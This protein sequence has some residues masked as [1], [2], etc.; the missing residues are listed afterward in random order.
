MR[1]PEIGRIVLYYSEH[2]KRQ[3][4]ALITAVHEFENNLYLISVVIFFT[5]GQSYLEDVEQGDGP[6]RWQW[7]DIPINRQPEKS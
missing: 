3:M 1:I 2:N 5:N 4:P 6:G 7:P